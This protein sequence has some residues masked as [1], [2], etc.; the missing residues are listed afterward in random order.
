MIEVILFDF[1]GTIVKEENNEIVNNCFAKAF[2]DNKVSID[3][4]FLKKER[5][6]DKKVIIKNVLH[7]LLL[8]RVL[9]DNIYL[10]F[11]KNILNNI[12]KFT[13]NDEATNI[14]LYLKAKS[15]KICIGTGLERDIFES[16]FQHLKWD[17]SLFDYIGIANEI[18]RSRPFPDMI[19]DMMNKINITD[20]NKILKVGDTV[21]DIQEGKN[22]KVLTAAILSGTHPESI[23]LKE[24]PDFILTTLFDLKKII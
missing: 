1:I 18:G 17:N 7:N 19:F 4:S 3:I 22:A 13:E 23:L 16:I 14:F 2:A 12:N 15:I 5:G 21:A 24:K 9:L 11:K 10:T 6:K 20:T 8:S